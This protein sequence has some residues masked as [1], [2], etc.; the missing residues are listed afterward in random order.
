M[1]DC[2]EIFHTLLRADASRHDILSGKAVRILC[3]RLTR[4]AENSII[5]V[6]AEGYCKWRLRPCSLSP[7][8]ALKTTASSSRARTRRTSCACCGCARARRFWCPTCS[9]TNTPSPSPA[10]ARSAWSARFF[11]SAS[12]TRKARTASRCIRRFRRRTSWSLSC[13]RPWNWEPPRWC[14]S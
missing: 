4:E 14:P 13:R 7:G 3:K 8:T 12:P 2:Q 9:G 6:K 1:P 5:F 10:Q 11:P